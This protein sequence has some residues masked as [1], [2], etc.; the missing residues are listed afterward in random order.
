MNLEREKEEKT[1]G[2]ARWQGKKKKMKRITRV[3][4]FWY[5]NFCL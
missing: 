2:G 5:R 3:M 4:W 1:K